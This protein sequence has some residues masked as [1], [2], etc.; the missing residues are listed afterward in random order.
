MSMI[1]RPA[2]RTDEP[3]G[4]ALHQPLTRNIDVY[5]RDDA[6]A[7]TIERRVQRLRLRLIARKTVESIPRTAFHADSTSSTCAINMRIVS[8]SGTSAP[9]S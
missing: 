7:A 1:R 9:R 2:I 5:Y 8:A 3:T 6:I 4:Q